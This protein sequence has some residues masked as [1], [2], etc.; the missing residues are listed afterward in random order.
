MGK[1]ILLIGAGGHSAVVT[2]TILSLKNEK[3]NLIYECIDYLD[4]YSE[5]AIGKV[6]ELQAIGKKY[7]EA[8]CCIGNNILREKIIVE[9]LN[10]GMNLPVLIHPSAY[11]S[12]SASIEPGTIVEPKAIINS[13]SNIGKG[14]IIS[15]GAIIDHNVKIE[16]YCHINAGVV[17][18]A[19]S[20]IKVKSKLDSPNP[21]M[22]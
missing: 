14:C 20:I 7:D 4:D 9:I 3:D 11:I 6:Q 18:K 1:K 17:C 8:F 16:N 12:P 13:N 2:E 10:L 21:I 15:T 22:S 5:K 19:G